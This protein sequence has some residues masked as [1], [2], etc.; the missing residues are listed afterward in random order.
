[1]HDSRSAPDLWY[2]VCLMNRAAARFSSRLSSRQVFHGLLRPSLVIAVATLCA[3]GCNDKSSSTSTA[4]SASAA[5]SV[6][7]P[8]V[9]EPASSASAPT[10]PSATASAADT[11]NHAPTPVPD[12]IAAQH[13][14]VI[15]KGA[16]NAPATVTRSKADAKKRA[17]EVVSKARNGADFT[18]LVAE[19]SDDAST[20]DRLGNLGKFTRD[21]MVKPFSDAAFT[22][23][24]GEVSGVVE[25]P[26]GFHVIKRNQ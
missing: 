16:K 23:N 15:Y 1:M 8:A 25:T 17:E 22:L 3:A 7:V 18:Q 14:L 12:A 19:Y 26:F 20:K 6:T 2:N 4:P 11:T 5:S 10:T 13:V 24:V 9:T 21:K